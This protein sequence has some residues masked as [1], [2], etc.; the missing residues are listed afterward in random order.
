MY[1]SAQLCDC[2][3]VASLAD[4]AMF[5]LGVGSCLVVSILFVAL[6]SC[7]ELRY[8]VRRFILARCCPSL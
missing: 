7:A 2:C 3:S 5:Q 8:S 1:A 6:R 4:F